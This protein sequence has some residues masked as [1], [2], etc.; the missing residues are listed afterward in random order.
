MF[1]V[2]ESMYS[3][4]TELML[5][6]LFLLHKLYCKHID[7]LMQILVCVSALCVYLHYGS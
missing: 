5:I 4:C 1:C 7:I 2:R 6:F 3:M